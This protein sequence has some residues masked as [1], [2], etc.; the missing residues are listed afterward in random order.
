[1]HYRLFCVHSFVV[2][3]NLQIANMV[4]RRKIITNIISIVD[5]RDKI[6]DNGEIIETVK[7][8]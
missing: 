6:F 4:I 7:I 8:R 2:I 3:L 5:I 1:M